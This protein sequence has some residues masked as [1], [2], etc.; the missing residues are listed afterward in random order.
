MS[1][2][3]DTLSGWWGNRQGR[4][5]QDNPASKPEQDGTTPQ[6][7][8]QSATSTTGG[9]LHQEPVVVWEA[10]NELEAQ[11]VK[12]KLESEGI[13]VLLRGEALGA[14]Y[15]LTTGALAATD[16]LVPAPLLDKAVDLLT[17]EEVDEMGD[18]VPEDIDDNEIESVDD[19]EIEIG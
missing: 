19:D 5:N 16:V 15:G 7:Q 12:S 2:Q 6:G 8:S 18:V 14:I 9:H 3:T 17:V 10:E 1:V 13:P 4:H 11:I